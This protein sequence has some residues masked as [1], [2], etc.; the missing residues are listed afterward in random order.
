MTAGPLDRIAFQLH[1]F[2][3]TLSGIIDTRLPYRQIALDV[4][5]F[6]P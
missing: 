5:D 4:T 3:R 2:R 6:K 1:E